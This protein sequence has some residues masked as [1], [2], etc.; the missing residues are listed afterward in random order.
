MFINNFP[1][2]HM[3]ASVLVLG[4][5]PHGIL[6]LV[7]ENLSRN[8]VIFLYV[9]GKGTLPRIVAPQRSKEK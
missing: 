4:G 3:H 1:H 2:M 9:N 7:V 6:G 8:K 5:K